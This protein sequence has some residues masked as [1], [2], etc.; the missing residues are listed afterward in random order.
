MKY[1]I[2]K[3][4]AAIPAITTKEMI[5]VARLM[6]EEFHISLP[7]MMEMAGRN[8]ADL[9]EHFSTSNKI[10]I[11]VFAGTGH[12]GG[13]GMTAARHLANREHD[14]S[15]CLIG[16]PKRLKPIVEKRWKTLQ[17]MDSV[18]CL[19]IED[20]DYAELENRL[21]LDAMI[22]Y[23]LMGK[24]RSDMKKIIQW[25]NAT[26]S[27]VVISLDAP[28]GLDTTS[29]NYDTD[30]C[31]HSDATMTLALPKIGLVTPEAQKVIGDLYLADIG[32]PK[33]VLKCIGIDEHNIFSDAPILRI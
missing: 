24:P 30:S 2:P 21:I 10:P 29:G 13:G 31:I 33:D 26:E 32:V 23:G 28:S 17:K 12:N 15:V 8:L 6:I 16:N 7:Q 1:D 25:I 4:K 18:S 11:L 19:Q 9:S 20:F 22:G 14:V 3:A 27:T 5:E